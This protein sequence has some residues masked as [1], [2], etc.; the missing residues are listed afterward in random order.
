MSANFQAYTTLH[1]SIL[2]SLSEDKKKEWK[3]GIDNKFIFPI[4]NGMYLVH[5]SY[6]NLFM[7]DLIKDKKDPYGIENVNFSLID[8][9]DDRWEKYKQQRLERGFDNSELWNLDSTI[10]KFILPR[11]KAFREIAYSTPGSLA[12]EFEQKGYSN[13]EANKLADKAWEEILDKIE[14]AFEN[15]SNE[16][17]SEPGKDFRKEYKKYNKKLDE[18]FKLFGKWFSAF[19]F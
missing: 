13:E 1:E 18:G 4:D 16:P 7:S 11:L 2:D 9:D 10:V 15:Y 19:W 12:Y 17:T 3:L 8:P 14:W 6:Y 5:M